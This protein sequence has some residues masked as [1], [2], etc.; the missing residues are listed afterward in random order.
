LRVF[1][2]FAEDTLLPVSLRGVETLGESFS[3]TIGLLAPRGTRVPSEELMG[4]PVGAE[5]RLE[6]NIR[7]F[8]HGI[9]WRFEWLDSR[10]AFDE[11]RMEIRPRLSLLSLARRSRVFQNLSALD[12]IRRV[13]EP[14][15][16]A[17]ARLNGS[18]P[19]RVTCAQYR[20]TDLEFFLRLC[21]EEGITHYWNHT[22]QD[23]QLVLTDSTPENPSSG[24]IAYD[25]RVG[26]TEGK[27]F[28]RSWTMAQELVPLAAQA[29]DAHPLRFGRKIVADAALPESWRAG[30]GQLFPAGFKGP[31]EEDGHSASRWFDS[32]SISGE[33]D[34]A[35]LGK[36]EGAQ[37][38]QA[39]ILAAAA[40]APA[41]RA[42]ATGDCSQLTAGH[43]MELTGHPGQSGHWL[44]VS[45]EHEVSVEGRYWAG[46]T[47]SLK[48][49]V[50]ASLAP[51][52][53]PQ[54]PWP[55]RPKPRVGGVCTATVVGPGPMNIDKF[56]RVQVNFPWDRSAKGDSCWVR[57]AQSWAGNG[58]GACFWPRV[59]HEVV[60][61]FEEGDP[62]RPVIVGS[63]YNGA[64]MPPFAMPDN[65]YIAGWKSL[66][67]GGDPARNYHQILMS[68]EKGA[69]IVHVH[70]EGSY[71]VQ[72]ETQQVSFKPANDIHF[73]G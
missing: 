56:G 28:I 13:L 21:S 40:A 43:A 24:A 59:G 53:L 66:T 69:E 12:I 55:P 35:A 29:L 7:R 64:N 45:V 17:E 60:V 34:P 47:A 10:D 72:Q 65:M 42:R 68:D 36:V 19:A 57:V 39:K 46:E 51:L 33:D 67:Q 48:R 30:S 14:V 8:F 25:Q 70:A 3:F 41:A 1:T 15:G 71:I 18:P 37:E 4:R 49:V 62:D 73:T 11:Y 2:P 23:H 52:A 58:W 22:P 38:R 16:G 61:A 50:N 44:A 32:V 54:A 9:V 5:L 20:E 27:P 26:G 6:D 63:V 31:W